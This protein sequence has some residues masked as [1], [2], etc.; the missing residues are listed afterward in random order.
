M[1]PEQSGDGDTALSPLDDAAA[2]FY[3]IGQVA[4][5]LGIQPAVLRRLDA[6]HI[7]S[8]DTSSRE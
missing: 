3:T 8:R 2:P 6:E 7:V 1:E 5:L 4:T